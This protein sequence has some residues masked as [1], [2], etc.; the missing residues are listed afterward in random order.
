MSDVWA[1]YSPEDNKLRIYSAA[2][3][4]DATYK[5]LKSHGFKWA[6]KQ[7][8]IA[9]AACL[10]VAPRWT[11]GAEDLLLELV[12]EIGDEDYSPEERSADRAERFSGYRDK[13]AAEAGAS[14]DTFDAGPSAFG[15]QSQARAERLAARHD[16]HRHCACSQWSK[17][18]YWQERT[19]AVIGHAL[20]KSSAPVRRSRIDT[21]EAEQRKHL[22]DIAESVERFQ[23]WQLVLTLPGA[24]QTAVRSESHYGIDQERSSLA[25]IAAYALVNS[26]HC[27]GDYKHP[28]TG[29]SASLY[30]LMVD[31]VDPITAAEAATL[32][33]EGRSSPEDP[34]SYSQR[35]A[36]HYELRLSYE[37]AMLENEGGRAGNVEMI[38][39]GWIRGGRR[40]G[41]GWRQIHRVYRSPATKRVTSVDVMGH[42][43]GYTKESDYTK[44]ETRPALV[45]VDVSRLPEDCYR[46]PTAEELAAF[47]QE[48]KEAKQAAK[49]NKPKE[50]TL[51]NPTEADAKRLQAAINKVGRYGKPE[52][53]EICTTT[54]KTYS[55][56]SKGDYARC[57]TRTVYETG[58]VSRAST[59]L[60]SQSGH[61]YD[62][63]LH[64]P[65]CKVRTFN[66]RVVVLSDKPQKALPLDWDI[67]EGRKPAKGPQA[68]PVAPEVE[69]EAEPVNV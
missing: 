22:K 34:D 58:R 63:T 4:D 23:G 25:A 32:W 48:Q 49:A 45:K 68:A 44:Q 19:A 17:A 12:D 6:P 60:W 31:P 66:G 46:E 3:F 42:V 65:V 39:G 2:R 27:Y 56:N 16:R 40:G 67:V 30:S 35:W 61:D 36:R 47:D 10:M 5:R 57:E 29:K 69:P 52:E 15:H 7:A 33:L 55:D 28:R 13:R 1:T 18:E 9:G 37:N 20:H 14:A 38:P 59:N 26:H 43:S 62:K 11:P 50:P 64:N 8:E 24:D 21:L 53:L 41:D 51:I 54:Q